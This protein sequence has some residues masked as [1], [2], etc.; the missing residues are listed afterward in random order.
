M[1]PFDP[2]DHMVTT[3]HPVF[4]IGGVVYLVGFCLLMI[5]LVGAW[6]WL[7]GA[8]GRLATFAIVV[9]LVGTMLLGRDLWFE[10]FAVPW[11]ADKAPASLDTEPTV[12]LA[13]GAITS[14]ALFAAGWALFGIASLRAHVFPAPI[15]I[16]IAVSGLVGFRALLAPW[17]VPLGLSVAAIGVWMLRTVPGTEMI[18]HHYRRRPLLRVG[19]WLRVSLAPRGRLV[20]STW[21]PGCPTARDVPPPSRRCAGAMARARW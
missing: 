17:C 11:L 3:Q 10:T 19:P 13:L 14:C 5:T 1:L 20:S 9:A 7:A 16:A 6:E 4:Q 15:C 21:T 12:L 18:L 8:A 2:K